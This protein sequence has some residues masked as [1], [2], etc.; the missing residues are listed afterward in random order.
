[1]TPHDDPPEDRAP[2]TPAWR[3]YTE[4]WGPRVADDVDDEL[5]FHIE[6]R[7]DDYVARG[8][9]EE[10]ARRLAHV[11]VGDIERARRD[12]VT[13]G[14]QR[15]SRMLRTR[16]ID[17]FRQDASFAVRSL[18]QRK[19]WTLVVMVTLALGIGANTAVF[20]LIDHVLLRPVA[21][22]GADRIVIPMLEMKGRESLTFGAS[23]RAITAWRGQAKTLDGIEAINAHDVM[24]TVPRGAPALLHAASVTPGFPAFAG[25]V[26]LIGRT[27]VEADGLPGAEPVVA[28]SE[29]LWRRRFG[30]DASVVG[31]R[32][33][34]DGRSHTI[35]GVMPAT[36]R[37]PSR[38]QASTDLWIALDLKSPNAGGEALARLR[39]GVSA[40]AAQDELS[41]LLA[42]AGGEEAQTF[43]AR[44]S[45][46]TSMVGFRDSLWMFGI[47]VAL[48]LFIVCGNVAHLLLAQAT[49]REREL[50][51]R[52]ALGAGRGR[53]ARLLMTET[54]LLG[55]L[56]CAGGVLVAWLGLKILLASRPPGL[57]YVAGVSLDMRALGV[58]VAL[59]L[60]TSVAFGVFASLHALR[61][62]T[63]SI[64]KS[65][66]T[67]VS[68]TRGHH[69]LRGLLIVSEIAFSAVLLVGA[70][71]LL[72]TVWNLN[73]IDPG[74]E[75]RGAYAMEVFLPME[76]YPNDA[77]R[78]AFYR[79]LGD[80]ARRIPGVTDATIAAMAPPGGRLIFGVLEPEDRPFAVRP[81]STTI[82]VNYVR[83]NFFRVLGMRF[84]EG[85]TYQ[86]TT[87]AGG[88]IVISQAAARALWPEGPAVGR[89]FRTSAKGKWWRVVGVTEDEATAGF[90]EP[91]KPMLFFSEPTPLPASLIVRSPDADPTA[92]LREL[93]IAMDP[94]LSAANVS[95]LEADLSRKTA[96]QQFTMTLLTVFTIIAVLLSAIGLHGVM[97]YAV[98]QRTRE[99]GVRVALGAT[100]GQIARGVLSSGLAWTVAGLAIGTVGAWWCARF[101]ESLLFGVSPTDAVSFAAGAVIL[102]GIS[103]LA[104]VVPARRAAAV[105]P[106]VAMRGD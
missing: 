88:E 25:E 24:L 65:S 4:L 63:Q 34:L 75:P 60:V 47:A 89:R 94:L 20:S 3:R 32:M 54:L 1:M 80:R 98:A 7:I 104:C 69:R 86:D 13:I 2:R 105:D 79:E 35:V 21:Y 33:T 66:G 44:L 39:P 31:T 8:M 57:S 64:L 19:G 58:A 51:V 102:I 6:M 71:M 46:L 37:V 59:S 68:A 101:I 97:S 77:A 41:V 10:D 100:S 36:L 30:G 106:I 90:G 45:P 53:I 40:S 81:K 23:A 18:A 83:Q 96:K 70:S 27:F 50:A 82:T 9:S 78:D 28:L 76:R 61:R 87:A 11:R 84:I 73:R 55:I 91:A 52:R 14:H 85:S 43:R 99:I 22:P 95:S 103:V 93:L 74:F 12:C 26:P 29:A 15:S 67:G 49:A 5:R 42:A 48:V 56:G 72:R 38:I 16:I 17:A 62:P 92:K